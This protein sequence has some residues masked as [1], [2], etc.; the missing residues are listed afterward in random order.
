MEK[1]MIQFHNN[2]LSLA[3]KCVALFTSGIFE[4]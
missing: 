4:C 1:N 2:C 3:G